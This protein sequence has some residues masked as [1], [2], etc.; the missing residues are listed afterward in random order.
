MKSKICL[1]FVAIFLLTSCVN[2]GDVMVAKRNLQLIS[3][4]NA[5]TIVKPV[6]CTL[7]RGE[8]VEI[9]DISTSNLGSGL[10][11]TV[12][13]VK[14]LKNPSCVGWSTQSNFSRP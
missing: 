14:S 7:G 6:A 13:R 4:Y 5:P 10:K 11:E 12:Y 9:I 3:N 2:I 1:V 8:E